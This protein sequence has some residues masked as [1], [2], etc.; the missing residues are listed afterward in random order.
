MLS[1]SLGITLTAIFNGQITGFIGFG[2]GFIG[3]IVTPVGTTVTSGVCVTVTAGIC[4]LVR[5][6][7]VVAVAV[8][9]VVDVTVA[10]AM[11]VT[12]PVTVIVTVAH[13]NV[14]LDTKALVVLTPSTASVP[15]AVPLNIMLPVAA[16][17]YTHV[18]DACKFAF[19]VVLAG[20]GPLTSV[21]VPPPD[22][23][24][25]DGTTLS[26]SFPPVFTTSI[27]TVISCPLPALAGNTVIFATRFIAIVGVAVGVSVAVFTGVFVA[28]IVIVGVIV[29]VKIV[30]V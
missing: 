23:D 14:L 20:L 22:C 11:T 12:V 8:V 10:V 29:T 30:A 19:I 13:I 5:V 25:A 18:N 21:A 7:S 6:N 27:T 2:Y 17:I 4:V 28:V 24:K 9:A 16:V 26:A 1:I 3:P 15:L